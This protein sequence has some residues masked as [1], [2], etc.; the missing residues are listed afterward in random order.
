VHVIPAQE[1]EIKVPLLI[2]IKIFLRDLQK[3]LNHSTHHKAL[4]AC[5][6]ADMTKQKDY[7]QRDYLTS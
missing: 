3:P 4:G 6:A 5:S 1:N 2:K 7:T